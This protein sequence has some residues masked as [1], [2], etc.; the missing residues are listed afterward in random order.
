MEYLIGFVLGVFV[1]AFGKYSGFD[2]ERAF[3]STVAAVV[4]TYYFL[5]AVMVH[6][7]RAM[8]LESLVACGFFALAV[9]GFK[10]NY[11]LI[12]VALVGH[13]AF[14]AVHHLLI[15][16]P[17]MPEWWPGFCGSIDVFMG[18]YLAF[19]LRRRSGVVDGGGASS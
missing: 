5:F 3:Y 1:C 15:H 12:V 14:D 2:R 16:N 18:T 13:A 17:G 11:W 4:A 6:A 10:K 7:T 19:L 8:V 9:A